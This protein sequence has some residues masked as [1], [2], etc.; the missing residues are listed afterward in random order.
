MPLLSIA[1]KYKPLS[2]S[3]NLGVDFANLNCGLHTSAEKQLTRGE[4]EM[5]EKDKQAEP[6]AEILQAHNTQKTLNWLQDW[7]HLPAGS[8]LYGHSQQGLMVNGETSDGYHTFNELYEFRKAYN[9]AL[10]NEWAALGKYSVHKS[11]R[12]HD[13]DLCFGGG[14]FIVLAVLP[15]GQISNHYEAKDW[16]LFNIPSTERALFEFDGHTGS[17]V[18]DRLKSYTP[19]PDPAVA[20]P[21]A[22]VVRELMETLDVAVCQN[23]HDMV[24]TGEELR[25]CE[26]ALKSVKEH[27]HETGNF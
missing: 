7:S 25:R 10:F 20:Q 9:A 4:I 23:S 17:D 8:K 21:P 1:D 27:G 11:W 2:P 12:H 15:E 5:N 3:P 6:V 26:A 19:H 24:M 14:W 22:E 16:K 13:G 18:L